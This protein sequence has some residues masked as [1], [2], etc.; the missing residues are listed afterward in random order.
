MEHV[1]APDSSNG[2]LAPLPPVELAKLAKW[3]FKICDDYPGLAEQDTC[4]RGIKRRLPGKQRREIQA[5]VEAGETERALAKEFGVSESGLANNLLN[6]QVDLRRTQITP[7]HEDKAVALYH[8]EMSTYQVVEEL[9]YS[10]GTSRRILRKRN[11]KTRR[12][13]AETV[14]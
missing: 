7:E 12:R 3:S 8:S 6:M 5:R 9:R 2:K 1:V 10:V 14:L 13:D 4:P 11:V